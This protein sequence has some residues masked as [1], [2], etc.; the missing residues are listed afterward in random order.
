MT[1]DVR[2]FVVA[3]I[4]SFEDR[5]AAMQEHI[6]QLN[7]RIAELESQVKKLASITSR[8]GLTIAAFDR[9]CLSLA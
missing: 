1:P 6:Y 8:A 9:E 7:G 2:V 3:L 5:L 4:K